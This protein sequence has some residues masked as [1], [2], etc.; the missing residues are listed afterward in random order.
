[1]ALLDLHHI[2]RRRGLQ[3]RLCGAVAMA[4]QPLHGDLTHQ[5][6]KAEPDDIKTRLVCAGLEYDFG[7]A[8]DRFTALGIELSSRR[9][10]V[11]KSTQCFR[12]DFDALAVATVCCNAP[13]TLGGGLRQLP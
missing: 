9:L 4:G 12:A 5:L 13:G 8:P 10:I 7:G 6:A 11:V 1:M 3:R 2:E